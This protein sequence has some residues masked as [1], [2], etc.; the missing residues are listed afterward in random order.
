M[1][2]A[3]KHQTDAQFA[4]R[5]WARARAAYKPGGDNLEFCRLV[6]WV[7]NQIQIGNLTSDQVRLSFN[8]AYGRSLNTSQWNTLVTS[9]LVPAKDKYL[10]ILAQENL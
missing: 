4:A 5:F 3:L 9:K 10:A 7:W 6:W 2:L 1:A 8:A